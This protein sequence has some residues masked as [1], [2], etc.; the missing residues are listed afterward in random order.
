MPRAES[1]VSTDIHEYSCN[2]EKCKAVQTGLLNSFPP[3]GQSPSA[4]SLVSFSIAQ[5]GCLHGTHVLAIRTCKKAFSYQLERGLGSNTHILCTCKNARSHGTRIYLRMRRSVTD[6]Y[7]RERLVC[8]HEPRAKAL[9]NN[10]YL[11]H[12]FYTCVYQNT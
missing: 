9:G 10:C 11:L 6:I 8:N 4:L 7:H 12:D 2:E 3:Q 1:I 5:L